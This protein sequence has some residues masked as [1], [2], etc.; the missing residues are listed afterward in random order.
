VNTRKEKEKK[1][2]RRRKKT[3]A[4]PKFHEEFDLK[5]FET[6]NKR[7]EIGK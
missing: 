6:I 1:G 3:S 7:S 2:E 4:N 5:C